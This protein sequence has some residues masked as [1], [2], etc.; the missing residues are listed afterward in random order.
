MVFSGSITAILRV[1]EWPRSCVNVCR[2]VL[3]APYDRPWVRTEFVR[4]VLD[5]KSAYCSIVAGGGVK[6]RFWS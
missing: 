4:P 1:V 5:L 6:W 2:H 3:S